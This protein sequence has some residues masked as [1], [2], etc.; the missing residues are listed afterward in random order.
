VLTQLTLQNYED[1]IE[2]LNPDFVWRVAARNLALLVY[3]ALVCAPILR[4][5]SARPSLGSWPEASST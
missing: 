2:V 3:V 4:G 5:L 1:A